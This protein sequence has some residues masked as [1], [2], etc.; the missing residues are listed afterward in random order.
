[1]FNT[2]PVNQ[3]FSKKPG[4]HYEKT[5]RSDVYVDLAV[6]EGETYDE[7]WCHSEREYHIKQMFEKKTNIKIEEL[8]KENER[9]L[10]VSGIA[11][12]GKSEMVKTMMTKWANKTLFNGENQTPK[13]SLLLMLEC[14]NLNTI[15]IS[16]TDTSETI[17]KQLF[18]NIFE[19]I[20]IENLTE[21]SHK[22]MIIIDGVDELQG[23]QKIDQSF[24]SDSI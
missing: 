16:D 17:L 23:A 1:M 6:I 22:I 18:P 8:L 11:G 3:P 4:L 2:Q 9:F 21:I 19:T 10:I 13:I 24:I 7:K 12:V 5:K 14:R 15:K 20:P